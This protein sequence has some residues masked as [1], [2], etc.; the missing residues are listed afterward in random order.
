MKVAY[1]L[2]PQANSLHMQTAVNKNKHVNFITGKHY[3]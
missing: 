2:A 3:E 1:I